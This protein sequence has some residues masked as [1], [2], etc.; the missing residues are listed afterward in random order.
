MA[1]KKAGG[2]TKNI[3]DSQPK[4]LGIK[5]GSGGT[6]KKGAIILRQRGTPY[7]AGKGVGVGKDHTLYALVD[8]KVKFGLKRKVSYT[9]KSK[10]LSTVSVV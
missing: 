4:Y 8:G 6:A 3:G 9:G 7:M 5:I 1:H 10:R 2:S